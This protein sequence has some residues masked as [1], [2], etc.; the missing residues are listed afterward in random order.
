MVTMHYARVERERAEHMKTLLVKKN[1]FDKSG[2]VLHSTS[3]VLFPINVSNANIKKLI[4]ENGGS[5]ILKGGTKKQ[6]RPTYEEVVARILPKDE[7]RALA[8]GYDLLG[9]IAIID[10]GKGLGKKEKE[11]ARALI[12][13][14]K[15]IK[16]VLAKAGPVSGKYRT[17]KLRYVAGK[18]SYIADYRENG[19]RFVFDVRKSFFSNRL[20]FER[21]RIMKLSKGKE[22]V[23]VMFAG[24]GPFA[25]EIAKQNPKA[26]V[27]AIELNRY[28]YLS[29]KE[30]VKINKA[31]NVVPLLADAKKISVK[32]RNFADR[33][34]MPLPMQSINFLDSAVESA[35]RKATIHIYMIV[36]RDSAKTS[37]Q[38][39]LM[40]HAK[41]HKYK[42]RLDG[43]KVVRDYSPGEV[44]VVADLK[45]SK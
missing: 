15:T 24:I 22:N 43:F 16:T 34:V 5:V 26:K 39:A 12:E 35:K 29:M 38:K 14:S 20:S 41:L 17:R 23:I 27:L 4:K 18:R 44:E 28:A 25:I 9:N 21:G 10:V 32:Y 1:L 37:A 2:E 42:V 13:S 36:R 31:S 8:R 30:N 6:G 40:H 7:R 3:Y 11:V 19:C 33:V 45:I